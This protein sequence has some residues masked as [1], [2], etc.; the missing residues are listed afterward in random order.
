M[1]VAVARQLYV[2]SDRADAEA[3]LARQASYTQRTVD[4]ARAPA[5][6]SGGSH[7]LAYAD[8]A[9]ETEAHALFGT[10]DE[11]RAGLRA[12]Q[13]AGAQYLLLTIF[14]GRTQL[15]RFAREVMPDFAATSLTVRL[16]AGE[17]HP[18]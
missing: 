13:A 17:P 10:P 15:R 14:G 3:A 16:T 6:G 5:G 18:V 2:A 4:V 7:V 8:H 9:G 1:Q 11:I 12:L